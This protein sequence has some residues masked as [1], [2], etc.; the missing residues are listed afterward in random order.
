[1]GRGVGTGRRQSGVDSGGTG[2]VVYCNK[3]NKKDERRVGCV[4]G[5]ADDARHVCKNKI[6]LAAVVVC[7]LEDARKWKSR[8]RE[9]GRMQGREGEKLFGFG[10]KWI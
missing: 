6:G 1:M 7:M 2:A 4:P 9:H 10:M 8:R 3:N 5:I